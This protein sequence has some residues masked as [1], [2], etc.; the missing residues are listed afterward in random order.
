MGVNTQNN[1]PFTSDLPSRCNQTC[2]FACV[3]TVT[4]GRHQSG[5]I[6]GGRVARVMYYAR[7][8]PEQAVLVIA[9]SCIKVCIKYLSCYMNLLVHPF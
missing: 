9:M 4:T 5:L 6:V 3:L 2:S 7:S 1:G 8:L